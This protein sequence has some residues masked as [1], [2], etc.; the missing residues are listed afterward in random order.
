MPHRYFTTEVWPAEGPG[1]YCA[2]PTPTIWPGLMRARIGDKL[3]L[4]DGNAV[5]YT[6]TVS[7]IGEDL[8]E[9]ADPGGVSLGG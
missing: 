6:A 1:P 5:E 7:S 3:I 9:C 4:C 8:V 2:G